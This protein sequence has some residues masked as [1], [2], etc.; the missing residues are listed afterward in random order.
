MP[1]RLNICGCECTHCL[2][3]IFFGV[4]CIEQCLQRFPGSIS[5]FKWRYPFVLIRFRIH[6]DCA[7]LYGRH[8]VASPPRA[9]HASHDA[10]KKGHAERRQHTR[11]ATVF[12]AT[13]QPRRRGHRCTPHRRRQQ[14]RPALRGTTRSRIAPFARPTTRTYSFRWTMAAPGRR[15]SNAPLL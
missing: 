13:R 2:E 5:A 1:R 9:I 7:S 3:S 10:R 12:A 6:S 11:C 4:A 15:H 14:R 8:G